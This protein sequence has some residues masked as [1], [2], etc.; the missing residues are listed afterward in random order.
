MVKRRPPFPSSRIL[1]R[2]DCDKIHGVLIIQVPDEPWP[3]GGRRTDFFNLI[4]IDI[5]IRTPWDLLTI[6]TH[7]VRSFRTQ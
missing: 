6:I 5:A 7:D 2:T 4:Q 3:W 1:D